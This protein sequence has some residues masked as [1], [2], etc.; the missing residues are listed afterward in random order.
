M[1]S[2][3]SASCLPPI[4]GESVNGLAAAAEPSTKPTIQS[5]TYW[6]IRSSAPATKLH[7]PRMNIFTVISW[8]LQRDRGRERGLGERCAAIIMVG[9]SV[10]F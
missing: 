10:K 9:H 6:F 3:Q 1:V 7:F 8:C 4:F 5:S 2:S